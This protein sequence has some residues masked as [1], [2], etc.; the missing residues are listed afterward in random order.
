MPDINEN[1]Y[2]YAEDLPVE[3]HTTLN[4]SKK[5]V[6]FDDES[7]K[8]ASL[9]EITEYLNEHLNV[10]LPPTPSIDG[11]YTL[12]VTITNGNP[13]YSWESN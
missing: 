8:Q 7:G 10:A 11:V 13:I 2:Q 1:D 3:D 12:K 5:F 6:M 4:G 9:G